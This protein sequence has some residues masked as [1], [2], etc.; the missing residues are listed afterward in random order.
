[1]LRSLKDTL[2]YLQCLASA[3]LTATTAATGVDLQDFGSCSFIV[4]VGDFAFSGSNK[5]DIVVQDSDV[6][7]D[8]T[9]AD[10][11]D[12]DIYNAE[13]GASGIAKSL[14]ATDDAETIQVVHYRGNKRFARIRLV[15]TGTVDVPI[16]VSAV[17]GHPELMPPL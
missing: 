7:V 3:S 1:M 6:D 10:C 9:Y 17:L 11:V 8:G 12:V 16:S 14:D 5:L 4:N 2:K 13:V 15:E